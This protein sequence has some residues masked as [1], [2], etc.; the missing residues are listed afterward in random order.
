VSAAPVADPAVGH[1]WPAFEVEVEAG[2]LRLLAK[3]IGETRPIHTSVE[4]ARAAGYRS[5]V[6][7]PTFAFCLLADSPVGAGYL[8]DI[9]IPIAQV[10]H[11]EQQFTFH[12][13]LCAGDRVRVTRRVA[14][15]YEKKGGALR[16]VVLESGV[17]MAASGLLVASGRQVM[18][19]RR[20]GP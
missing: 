14:D 19:Q 9:G 4:A 7:P 11:A 18:V 17:R 1:A 8:A 20:G 12:A 13:L 2:R 10:L 3:A 5:L 15:A 16:F 6:A